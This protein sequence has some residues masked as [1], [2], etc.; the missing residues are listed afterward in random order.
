M[1]IFKTPF[2]NESAVEERSS[3]KYH[4]NIEKIQGRYASVMG[5]VT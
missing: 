3:E 4:G 1:Q 2:K 5:I